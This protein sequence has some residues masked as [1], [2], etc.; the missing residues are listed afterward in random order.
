M[1]FPEKFRE[2]IELRKPQVTLPDYV[3]LAYA[4]CAV[5]EES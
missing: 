1:P 4:T 5:E 2:L 3:W